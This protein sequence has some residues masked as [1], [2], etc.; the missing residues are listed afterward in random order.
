MNGQALVTWCIWLLLAIFPILAKYS[1][2]FFPSH[3]TH[4]LQSFDVVVTEHF[5]AEYTVAQN[6]WMM[7]DSGKKNT[8]AIT[9]QV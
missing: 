1:L 4:H 9:S 7:A 6:D 3:C 8:V 2:S 5:K